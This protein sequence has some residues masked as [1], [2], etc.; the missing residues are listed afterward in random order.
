M[1]STKLSLL[2]YIQYNTDVNLWLANIR[3]RYNPREGND[4][5]IVN[6]EGINTHLDREI[7]TLPRSNSRTL[8]LKYT[9]TFGF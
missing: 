2:G 6:N 1:F 8:L 7:P 9:Y 4:F 5:Y 3:F